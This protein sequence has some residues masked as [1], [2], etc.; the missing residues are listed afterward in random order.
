MYYKCIDNC[1]ECTNGSEC[2]NCKEGYFKL[3]NN[4]NK[5]FLTIDNCREYDISGKCND[6]DP[7]YVT[8]ESGT[9]CKI[10]IDNCIEVD[11]SGQCTTCEENYRLSNN[12]CYRE[13]EKCAKY[14]VDEKCQKCE[15]G[16][17]FEG[18]DRLNCKNIVDN[19]EEYYSKD[20]GLSYFKCDGNEVGDIQNC[21][22]C[23]YNN[24]KLICNE[25]KDTYVL[26]DDENNKCYS[27]E[28]FV[29]DNKYYYE[30]SLHIKTCS[31]TINKYNK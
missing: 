28:T 15:N 18:N 10:G 20:D 30:D 16:Y 5:C 3:E 12:N 11:A 25:C 29:N 21:K 9:I 19:F 17:A 23:I 22:K 14:E 8:I 7:G 4:N 1:Q 6:C 13:I 24:N 26:K 2:I 27:K 31:N